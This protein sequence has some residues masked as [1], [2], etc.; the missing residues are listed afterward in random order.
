MARGSIVGRKNMIDEKLMDERGLFTFLKGRLWMKQM[1]MN[2]NYWQMIVRHCPTVIAI[3]DVKG[4]MIC[5]QVLIKIKASERVIIIL[6]GV[7]HNYIRSI[8][9]RSQTMPQ[10]EA[11]NAIRLYIFPHNLIVFIKLH[12]SCFNQAFFIK[13]VITILIIIIIVIIIIIIFRKLFNK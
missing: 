1:R 8:C 13:F 4:K 12:N 2:Y 7:S 11:R 6:Y 3:M 10:P 5:G 9:L